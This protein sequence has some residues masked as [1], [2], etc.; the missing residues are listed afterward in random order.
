MLPY[1]AASCKSCR[2]ESDVWL[3]S[4]FYV[5]VKV[6]AYIL[7]FLS[8]VIP[9]MKTFFLSQLLSCLFT[10][11]V[12]NGSI[13]CRAFLNYNAIFHYLS[14]IPKRRVNRFVLVLEPSPTSYF[15]WCVCVNI[16]SCQ[17][18]S[19][20]LSAC[21]VY[22]CKTSYV[23]FHTLCSVLGISAWG[24]YVSRG[25]CAWGGSVPEGAVH[26]GHIFPVVYY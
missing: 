5:Y 19:N 25:L 14:L 2:Y 20:S 17:W 12:R 22:W 10:V 9:E 8:C 6:T 1:V 4:S 16:P 15:H 11:W 24:G 21:V 7:T 3:F 13:W 26:L 23:D 18:I